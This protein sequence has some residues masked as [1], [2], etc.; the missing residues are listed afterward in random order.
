MSQ[1]IWKYVQLDTVL[2]ADPGWHHD[3]DATITK[4]AAS[5]QRH[6][7]LRVLVVRGDIEDDTMCTLVEG[8][9]LLGAML[10]LG[11][12]QAMAVHL[13]ALDADA[14]LRV[15]W[16]LELDFETDYSLVVAALAPL[17]ERGVPVAELAAGG[18]LDAER[19]KHFPALSK[20]DWGV[21][22]EDKSQARLDWDALE[23]PPMLALDTST[24]VVTRVDDGLPAPLATVPEGARE[25]AQVVSITPPILPVTPQQHERMLDAAADVLDR[26]REATTPE[27][28]ATAMGEALEDVTA[29]EAQPAAQAAAPP[30]AA[31][32]A[33]APAGEAA[34]KPGKAAK[35]KAAKAEKPA[36]APAPAKVPKAPNAQLGLF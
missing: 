33:A 30:A 14:A 1:P 27:M 9:K 17:M 7:Q 11:W 19:L 5:L 28:L 21:F 36:K 2:V 10:S 12:T 31:E 8:H 23:E 16:A 25:Q 26:H 13:G 35:P 6:G 18:P 22:G 34:A 3:D 20:L 4:L 24:G 32:P 29:P 15:A